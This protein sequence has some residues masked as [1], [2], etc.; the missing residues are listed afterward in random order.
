M[1]GLKVCWLLLQLQRLLEGEVTLHCA[2]FLTS[3]GAASAAQPAAAF[4]DSVCIQAE[5]SVGVCNSMR[6]A[7]GF[8]VLLPEQCC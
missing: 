3:A 5:G 6:A 7:G 2:A 4:R 1:T 8:A